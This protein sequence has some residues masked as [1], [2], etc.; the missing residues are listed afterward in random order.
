VFDNG[1]VIRF[2]TTHQDALNLAGATLDGVLF[3]EPPRTREIYSEVRKR[4]MT[5]GGPL[6]MTLTPINAPTDWLRA[7]VERGAVVDLHFRWEAANFIPVGKKRPLRHESGERCDAA[8]VQ[9]KR[10]EEPPWDAAVRLDGEWEDREGGR[11]FGGFVDAVGEPGSNVVAELPNRD[12]RIGLGIDH[13][14]TG[15]NQAF[16]LVGID[17]A[18]VNVAAEMFPVVGIDEHVSETTTTVQQDAMDVL[19]MLDRNGLEWEDLAFVGGDNPTSGR[20]DRKDNLRLTEA[21]LR[22]LRR[23]HPDRYAGLR[24]SDL[25]PRITAAKQGRL[26]GKGSLRRG[27]R[28]LDKLIVAKGFTVHECCVLFRDCMRRYDGTKQSEHKHLPDACRYALNEYIKGYR[29]PSREQIAEARR[30]AKKGR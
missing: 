16:F 24:A 23:R 20:K 17:E 15:Q 30:I 13:G 1:S 19:A 8:W 14:E 28:W 5:T 12:L 18:S 9:R 3:D 11:R 7:E 21:I 22:E 2:K 25:R 10:D 26:S 27:E 6:L 29:L 4:L